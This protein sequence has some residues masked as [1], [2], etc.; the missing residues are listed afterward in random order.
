MGFILTIYLVCYYYILTIFNKLGRI[1]TIY[2]LVLNNRLLS[3][4]LNYL[5]AILNFAE[6]PFSFL[7][8]LFYLYCHYVLSF[9][10]I[11]INYIK[12]IMFLVISPN[13]VALFLLLRCIDAW[14]QL[15]Q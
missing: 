13:T 5:L 14:V 3:L 7:L 10:Y 1:L 6:T 12:T 15:H 9:S 11:F 2:Y 8:Y 4:V